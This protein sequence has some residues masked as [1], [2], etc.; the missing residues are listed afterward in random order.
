MKNK[1]VID[2][3]IGWDVTAQNIRE[4]LDVMSGPVSVEISS[5]GGSIFE[6]VTIFNLLKGYEGEVTTVIT[7]LA[8]SMA[9]YIAMAGDIR[10]AYDNSV[11]MIHNAWTVAAGDHRDLRKD[12]DILDGLTSM[13]SKKFTEVTGIDNK[14]IRAMMDEESFFYGAEIDEMGF[15][16]EIIGTDG[17]D[18][19][20]AILALAKNE[21]TSCSLKVQKLDQTEEADKLVAMFKQLPESMKQ[22][23]NNLNSKKGEQM[24]LSKVTI[25]AL[26]AG[27]P[28][29]VAEIK[30]T[31]FSDGEAKGFTDGAKAEGE[32]INAI[33]GLDAKGH[34]DVITKA[35]ADP[36]MKLDQV[37]LALYDADADATKD[38][39]DAYAKDGDTLAKQGAELN[40][41]QAPDESIKSDEKKSEDMMAKAGKKARGEK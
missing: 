37:K 15:V 7:G 13:L 35:L 41:G 21:F 20:V 14:K 32:R 12:A 10:Q 5:P 23:E 9:S 6:G 28:E 4:A 36:E 17:E 34:K 16:T 33:N 31:G 18:D 27:N 26:L 3:I 38:R 40:G 22:F 29:L 25:A 1:I 30:A 39:K 8:A 2:G 24:D 19:K 11:F